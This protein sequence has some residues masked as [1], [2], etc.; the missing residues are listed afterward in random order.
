[1]KISRLCSIF[2]LLLVVSSVFA[3]ARRLDHNTWPVGIT[4]SVT[5]VSAG[6]PI[7]LT[8]QMNQSGSSSTAVSLTSSAPQYLPVP[9]SITVPA[10]S[11]SV[12]AMTPDTGTAPSVPTYVTITAT[13][14]GH[15]AQTTVLVQ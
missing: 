7:L 6:D 1:M 14:N 8:V 4:P 15:S 11:A 12:A 10:N 3:A 5:T 13:A 9:S 2:V